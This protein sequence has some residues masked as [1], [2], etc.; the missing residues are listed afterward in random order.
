MSVAQKVRNAS[1]SLPNAISSLESAG[2]KRVPITFP[3]SGNRNGFN[4]QV[5]QMV[6]LLALANVPILTT[7][8]VADQH[9]P[10]DASAGVADNCSSIGRILRDSQTYG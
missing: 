5:V 2:V 8:A 9:H 10:E 6:P 7:S 1:L 3:H 4:S